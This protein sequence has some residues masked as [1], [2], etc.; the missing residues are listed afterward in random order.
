[1]IVINDSSIIINLMNSKKTPSNDKLTSLI[2]RIQKETHRFQEVT[3]YQVWRALNQQVDGLANK[4]TNLNEGVLRKNGGL[5]V[6]A[7][8]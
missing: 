6:Q 5:Y 2:V 4:A 8:P 1:M 3:F 7:I